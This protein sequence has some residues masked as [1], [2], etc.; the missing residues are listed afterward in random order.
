MSHSVLPEKVGQ[1]LF[2]NGKITFF[3]KTCVFNNSLLLQK[4]SYDLYSNCQITLWT[5]INCALRFVTIENRRKNSPKSFLHWNFCLLFFKKLCLQQRLRC[6]RNDLDIF[7]VNVS[8]PWGPLFI[9]PW[10]L[11]HLIMRKK[12]PKTFIYWKNCFFF[13]YKNL[14]FQQPLRCYRNDPIT[15]T[16]VSRLPS[17]SL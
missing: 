1:N 8:I 17:G 13:F 3:S 12:R 4:L 7:I 9:V 10:G 16:V 11:S 14:C 6:Y 15:S 5:L 2:F